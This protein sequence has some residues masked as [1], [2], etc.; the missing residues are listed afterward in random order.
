MQVNEPST[1]L[2]IFGYKSAVLWADEISV[3]APSF[4]PLPMH[5]LSVFIDCSGKVL[6]LPCMVQYSGCRMNSTDAR[7]VQ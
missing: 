6:E 7:N 2:I 3:Q 5:Y 4:P 1:Q